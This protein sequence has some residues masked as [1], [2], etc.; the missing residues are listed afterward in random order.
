MEQVLSNLT[1]INL[2]T[3][4]MEIYENTISTIENGKELLLVLLSL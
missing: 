1:L 3:N 2:N 4:E